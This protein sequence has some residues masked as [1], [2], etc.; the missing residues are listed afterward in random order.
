MIDIKQGDCLELMKGLADESI[1]LVITS[2]PYNLG[3]THHTQNKRHNPYNDNLP[4][5]DYQKWQINI[6]NECYRILKKD[7]SIIYNHKNRIKNGIQSTPYEWILKTKFIVKQE[8]VWINGSPNFEK[9]RFYPF[10][11]RLYW[12]A[13]NKETQLYNVASKTDVFDWMAIGTEG[14]HTRAFPTQLVIDMIRVFPNAKSVFDPFMGSGTTGVACQR[15]GKDFIGFE[16]NED[17]FKLAEKR[18]GEAKKQVI[19]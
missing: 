3:N 4:E 6:L 14:E 13:K 15:L 19:L 1:D 16:I 9:I 8:L 10:T 18:I 7:G 11:E 12:L 2:P 5:D 17:Y